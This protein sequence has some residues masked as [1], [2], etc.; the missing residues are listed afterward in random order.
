MK[1]DVSLT[2]RCPIK[3]TLIREITAGDEETGIM[4]KF[5]DHF[6]E[7]LK[8]LS[9]ILTVFIASL[10]PAL[11]FHIIYACRLPD[12][13]PIHFHCYTPISPSSYKP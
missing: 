13:L 10:F 1:L 2:V 7:I 12:P 5:E 3:Y 8:L 11:C 4:A 9:V 6:L